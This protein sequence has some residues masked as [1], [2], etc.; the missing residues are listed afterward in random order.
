MTAGLAATGIVA[1]LVASSPAILSVLLGSPI[2]F[3]GLMFAQLG[4]VVA[5]SSMAP[6]VTSA[7]A[8]LMF[9]AYAALTGITFSTIF[10]V[11]TA[12]SI[13]RVFFIS[14]GAFAGLSIF[15]MTTKRDLGVI[16]RFA[17]FA[18]IGIIVASIVN[19]FLQSTGLDWIVS[20]AGVLVFGGLTAYDTQ[21]LKAMFAQ[22]AVHG[23]LPL[24]GALTLY[25]DFINMFLFLLRIFGRRRA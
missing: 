25:L 6:R 5:F 1:L 4:L 21:R 12:G 2:L 9:F 22:G 14:A 24:I 10:L 15:G 20:I 11:Y 13:A 23:N 19:I 17:L 3:Y 7:T 8:A 16:G 18:I